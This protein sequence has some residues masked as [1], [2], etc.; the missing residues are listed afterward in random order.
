MGINDIYIYIYVCTPHTKYYVYVHMIIP[1][2]NRPIL[3]VSLI[4]LLIKHL[5]FREHSSQSKNIFPSCSRFISSSSS[6]M[7]TT[8]IAVCVL[9]GKAVL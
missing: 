2:K 5:H 4:I 7:D 9:A 8:S 6:T 1:R 3:L